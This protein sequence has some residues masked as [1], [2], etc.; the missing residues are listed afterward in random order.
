MTRRFRFSACVAAA[1]IA[2]RAGRRTRGRAARLRDHGR[3]ARHRRRAR[4]RRPERSSCERPDRRR[5][6]RRR[7][8]RPTPWS[9]TAPDD[10]LPGTD[11]HGQSRRHRH[12]CR[13]RSSRSQRSRTSDECGT[14]RSATVILR[15]QCSGGRARQG[16]M[17]PSCR[18]W[19]RRHH[20]RSGDAAGRPVQGTQRAR[21]RRH[22]GRFAPIV[23]AIA[24]AAQSAWA[25]CKSPV[26]LHV[27]L[28]ARVGGDG[29]PVA[30]L[31]GIAFVRQSFIDARV[32]AAGSRHATRRTPAGSPRP[33]FD[34]ALAVCDTLRPASQPARASRWRSRP[35]CSARSCARSTWPRSSSCR[36]S[37]PAAV[38]AD[39]AADELK[40]A[41]AKVIL[42]LNYPTR[43]RGAA[44]GRRRA[45]SRAAPARARAEDGGAA[46]R[47]PAWPFAFSS[48][49]LTTRRLREERR[50]CRQEGF[51]RGRAIRALTLDA[52]KDRRRR[53]SSRF[54]REGQDRQRHHDN[55]DLF[56]E[57]TSVTLVFI[58]G[59]ASTWKR[60]RRPEA[61]AADSGN[62]DRRRR[63]LDWGPG[64]KDWD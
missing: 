22:A 5:R 38:E 23:G 2:L 55:G 32:P 58:D 12:P 63:T 61:A 6:R 52:A 45:R 14:L 19:R 36:R 64:T 34:R 46:W 59:R 4:R 57:R 54:A 3:P 24:A 42:S 43:S 60:P 40:A 10:R 15:P 30:L 27:E 18:G 53:R 21:E 11:R 17:R 33:R 47:R 28:Q 51:R 35:A 13:P 20:E 29:Y 62:E 16:S 8:R 31:G 9:S 26:A 49:G 7:S 50:P 39:L 56:A 41:K 37:S 48:S 1:A 25:S 44:A